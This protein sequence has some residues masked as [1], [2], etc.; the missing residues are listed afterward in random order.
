VSRVLAVMMA[1]LISG[2]CGDGCLAMPGGGP[3]RRDVPPPAPMDP[4]IEVAIDRRVELMSIVCRLAG[5][6]EYSK[7]PVTDYARAVDE[8]FA[9]FRDHP[10]VLAAAALRRDH[11]ISFNAPMQLAL[12]LDD[13]LAPIRPLTPPL[14]LLDARWNN[15]DPA[16]FVAALQDFAVASNFEQFFH[17]HFDFHLF[18]V[19]RVREHLAGKRVV[20][21][22]D[23]TFGPRPR[24]RFR[25]IPG[26]LVGDM[27][28]AA[29]AVAADGS[30]EIAQVFPL[31]PPG[32]DGIP[33]PQ[34]DL[35]Y[36][37]VHEFA[38]SYVNPILDARASVVQPAADP[39]F[40]R[41]AAI[42]TKQHYPSAAIMT[43]ESVVRALV[44]LYAQERAGRDAANLQLIAERKRGFAWIVD[45]SRALAT[46]KRPL[47]PD[48]V[49]TTTRDVFTAWSEANPPP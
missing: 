6:P 10:A 25:A 2:G 47:D 24:A 8:H 9:E 34:D 35:I 19:T 49:A 21:W 43:H 12:Y 14:P 33:V 17:A 39:V 44:V 20:D 36:Y 29:G 48:A 45:L 27:A 11:G 37:L 42:M 1:A 40:T 18:V 31:L 3:S 30:E 7:P 41:A 38:H 46:L 26:L 23:A 4:R 16:A 32:D 5:Y 28:Y 13:D 15:A 22:F